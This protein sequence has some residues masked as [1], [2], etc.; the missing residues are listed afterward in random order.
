MSLEDLARNQIMT[1][2]GAM[3]SM[4][5]ESKPPFFDRKLMICVKKPKEESGD[6]QGPQEGGGR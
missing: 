1:V 3:C 2:M 4:I 5:S 6:K